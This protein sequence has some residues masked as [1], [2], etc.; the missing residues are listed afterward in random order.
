[1]S[2]LVDI[3]GYLTV[4]LQG[5]ALTA[6]ATTVG[7]VAFRAIMP[8]AGGAARRRHAVLLRASAAVLAAAI[9]L[10]TLLKVTIVA[11]T[12]GVAL[13][14]VAGAPFVAAGIVAAAGAL[15]VVLAAGRVGAAARAAESVGVAAAIVG[16]TLV[17]HAVARLDGRVALAVATA[18]HLVAASL[19]IGGIP[20][21]LVAL[22]GDG[23]RGEMRR[24][25]AAFSRVAAAS[26]V[27]LGLSGLYLAL[28]YLGAWDAVY[29]TA[30][31]V[32]VAT[33]ALL[34][35]VLLLCGLH[36]A[37]VVARMA[38]DPDAPVLRLRRVAEAEF[39][40]ALAV[41]FA[42][43]S[44]TSVPPGIDLTEDRLAWHEL[45]E[46]LTPTWPRMTSPDHADLAIPTLQAAAAG[47]VYVPGQAAP[48]PRNASDIGWS[49][50]NHHWA[51]AIVL[52]IGIAALLAGSGVAWARHWPL[53]FLALAVFLG[54]RSDPE[55]WPLGPVGFW[56]G[57]RNPEVAQHRFFTLVI[58]GF[59]FF[60]WGVQTGRW[61]ARGTAWFFPL[62]TALAATLLLAHS[63]AIA[64]FKDLLII[65]ISHIPIALLGLAAAWGRWLELRLPG[66]E[67]RLAGRLWPLGL[68]LTGVTLLLYR[69]A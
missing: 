68:A 59:A 21:F 45:V 56:E 20:Y 5:I 64:N 66:P 35:G 25:G 40:I 24:I 1:M 6:T 67:G 37:R 55:S 46:R 49:E 43:A 60:E 17:S 9:L 16:L 7:G 29:G 26:V 32:M 10:A 13:G 42:A 18:L 39:G 36:N 22:A 50:Y 48:A 51:G 4:L 28:R 61:R 8:D 34:F 23:D 52:A 62:A 19:W 3:F 65:E 63:H 38:C 53:L 12:L 41:L 33:K 30:Y 58:V 27:L 54:F 44:L 31:G 14:D 57:F 11:G 2:F 47:A 69:E 15:A